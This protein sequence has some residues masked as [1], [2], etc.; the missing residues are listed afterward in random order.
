[1]A[2]SRAMRRFLAWPLA[3][4]GVARLMSDLVALAC[5]IGH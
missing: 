4:Y 5:H 1:M 2:P 3:F